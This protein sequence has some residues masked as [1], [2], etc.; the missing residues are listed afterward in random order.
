MKKIKQF[1][2]VLGPG[3]ITGAS[4]DDPTA[5]AAY[6][7]AGAQFGYSQLWTCLFTFPFMS[8][9]QEMCGRIGMVT[10][11]GL[12]GVIRKHYSKKLLYFAV[13]LLII[14]NIINIGAD[15]GAMAASV[16]LVIPVPF[17]VWLLIFTIIILLME[18]FISYQTYARYLK[19]L[20][21]T[22]LAYVATALIVK[23]D[24][25]K[26]I[27][28]TFI[29][30]LSTDKKYLL[31]LVAILGGN[32]SPYLFFWQ[33]SEEVEEEVEHHKIRAMGRG[34]P[35][36]RTRD[37]RDLKIDTI[38]GMIFS[39]VITLFIGITAASTLGAHGISNIA[40]ASDAAL[41]LK[42]LAGN[43]SFLFF[44]LGIIGSGLLAVPV[45]S[46]S[47][48][49]AIAEAFG[50]KEGLYRKFRKAHGFY[51]VITIATLVGLIINFTQ[52]K[53]FTL[54]YYS[55]ALN[56]IL[57]V[58]LLIVIILVC[59]NKFIM[60][61]YTNSYSSNVLGWLITILMTIAA[62]GLVISLLIK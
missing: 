25:T 53:P 21:L 15:L 44:A 58:P 30:Y 16:Q 32:I 62:L 50:W 37:L 33:A 29:P 6:S 18:V 43:F 28:S 3:F 7:Q 59:N 19:Y 61:G 42:P 47:G 13:L 20:A 41:A 24:W 45:L 46:G 38:I 39:N 52:I 57:A 34:V 11:K 1:L 56:G 8:V 17:S 54:L 26:I 12:A 36:I 51:G 22:L 60:R 2:K 48:S 31:N 5:I 14:A 10:G 55:A 4:D 27:F 9:I 23:Q 49:Y 40:T 35:K